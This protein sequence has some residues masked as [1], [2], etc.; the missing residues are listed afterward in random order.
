[1]HLPA[2][3]GDPECNTAIFFRRVV[4]VSRT[5]AGPRR[6]SAR[7][8]RGRR[9][10]SAASPGRRPASCSSRRS[11]IRSSGL[12]TSRGRPSGAIQ[13]SGE[14]RN[15]EPSGARAGAAGHPPSGTSAKRVGPALNENVNGSSIPA[16][17]RRARISA[18]AAAYSSGGS[19]SGCQPSAS[20]AARRWAR[21]LL[22][23]THTGTRLGAWTTE[24]PSG[25]SRSD[26]QEVLGG[27]GA[28]VVVGAEHVELA[29]QVPDAD[30]EDESIA[31]ERAHRADHRR[32]RERVAVGRDEHVGAD[33]QPGRAT[34]RPRARGER[35]EERRLQVDRGRVVG[36]RDVI[37]PPH[38]VE[39]ELL[40]RVDELG[41]AA[42][43]AFPYA[44]TANPNL[45]TPPRSLAS[46]ST[47][48]QAVGEVPARRRRGGTCPRSDRRGGC[49]RAHPGSPLPTRCSCSARSR[50]RRRR[51]ARST[52]L[53]IR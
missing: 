45:T 25:G 42:V 5:P 19:H 14:Y 30:A 39:A 2:A 10:R 13:N 8:A 41:D 21:R 38:R 51:R 31:G 29:A 48:K 28:R 22:P 50:R 40:T 18:R 27:R 11:P 47:W 49:A 1:M 20:S 17:S 16:S 9:C 24:N 43:D 36:H 33:A 44:G 52:R 26:A 37:R 4:A 12:P 34:E 35:L 3:R 46:R 32:D 6:R 53:C 7:R 15:S 23:P